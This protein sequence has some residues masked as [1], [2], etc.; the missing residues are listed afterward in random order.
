VNPDFAVDIN[1][2]NDDVGMQCVYSFPSA[3]RKKSYCLYAAP[4]ADA[5]R[6]AS[7]QLNV[8][9]DGIVESAT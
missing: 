1:R 7:K 6:E 8:P 9:A 2:I 3:D 4:S 5:I